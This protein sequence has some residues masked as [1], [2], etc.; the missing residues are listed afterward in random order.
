MALYDYIKTDKSKASFEANSPEEAISSAPGIAPTSGVLLR[1]AAQGGKTPPSGTGT[2]GKG[3]GEGTTDSALGLRDRYSGEK[4]R[5]K[6]SFEIVK[7][8]DEKSIRKAAQRRAQAVINAINRKYREIEAADTQQIDLMNRE[9]RAGNIMSGLSGSDVGS[10]R[11]V[12]TANEGRELQRKTSRMKE[13]E[14]A[15]TLANAEARASEEFRQEKALYISQQKDRFT[16]EQSLFSRIAEESKTEIAKLASGYKS[17]DDFKKAKPNLIKQYLEELD[18]DEN[19]LKAIFLAGQEPDLLSKTPQIVGSK[20]IWFTQGPDGTISQTSIDLPEGAKE[21][22]SSRITDGG[23]QVLYTDGTYKTIGT[24]GNK[25]GGG[26]GGNDSSYSGTQINELEQARLDGADKDTKDF[27]V[28]TPA[29]FR[30]FYARTVAGGGSPANSLQE[31]MSTYD[32]WAANNDE[33]GSG[34]S[35]DGGSLEERLGSIINEPDKKWWE[36]WKD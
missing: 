16:A 21:I 6:E 20:A 17:Y 5:I 2:G 22:A 12:E 19:G 31:L 23:V 8:P 3:S 27:Y 15:E 7:A 25:S 26:S 24:P 1:A 18:T 28:N 33:E 36:F 13:A 10:R 11:T 34:G 29:K 14:I 4:K 9:Q 35:E 30:D 32:D